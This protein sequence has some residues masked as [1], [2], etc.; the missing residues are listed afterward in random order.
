MQYWFVHFFITCCAENFLQEVNMDTGKYCFG[1]DDTMTA[2]D[3][4]A[5]ETLILWEGTIFL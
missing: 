1:V 4:G 3:A 2:L 5:V